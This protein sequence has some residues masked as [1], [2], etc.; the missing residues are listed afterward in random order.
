MNVFVTCNKSIDVR[1][2]ATIVAAKNACVHVIEVFKEGLYF[3]GCV[4]R[5][6]KLLFMLSYKA[7]CIIML[8]IGVM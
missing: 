6:A 4:S 5:K 3:S 2:C 1:K 8:F 7:L